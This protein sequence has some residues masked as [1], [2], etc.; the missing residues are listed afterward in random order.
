MTS[1]YEEKPWL[2]AYPP[3]VSAEIEIPNKSVVDL[4]NEATDK[5]KDRTALVFY[6]KKISF[7]ELREKADRFANALAH[8]GI[9]KGERVGLLALNS[10]EH[11]IAFFGILKAGAIVSSISPVYVSSEVKHQ[12]E[13]GGVESIVCQDMLFDNVEKTGL[14]FKNVILTNIAESLPATKKMFGKSILRGVYQTMAVPP[15]K[16]FKKEGF[17]QFQELLKK[18]APDPPKVEFDLREDVA[19][20]QYTGG[21][22]GPPKGVMSTHYGV[23]SGDALFHA[24]YPFLEDGKE[25]MLAYMPFY[26]AAGQSF[27]LMSGIFH[28]YTLI[29]LTTPDLDDILNS[30]VRHKVTFILG[31]PT[32]YELLKDY[33]KTDRVNWHRFKIMMSGADALL[34]ST[35]KEWEKRTGV[36]IHE[37]YGM[38]ETVFNT[39]GNP[40]GKSRLGSIGVP[41]TGTMA[42]ILDPDEDKFVP[43][44]EKGELVMCG[45]QITKGYWDNHEATKD[46]EAIIDGVRWWRSGD[47][48]EM[49]KDGYFSIYDRKRDLIKY[50]GLRVYAREVEEVLKTHPQIRETGVIGVRDPEVGENVK[51]MIVL[52]PDARG[53]L[54]E[55]DI[56]EYCKDKLTPYKIPKIVEFIGEIPKTDVGKVS[57]RELR[58]EDL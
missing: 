15:A 45:P 17:Y 44:G 50:K 14:E 34:E 9:K 28:G 8:L 5:W 10:P 16:I 23:A 56:I 46:C 12:L 52:E 41:I 22:T 48:A 25:V 7:G 36:T 42:A 3:E 6:G 43:Q 57:R 29:V 37:C 35:A 54:S 21:T 47:L 38:T 26:H 53:K 19:T 2:K 13:D 4:F 24:F 40:L 51:A 20:L 1:V 39:H 27:G 49:G 11:V 58:E 55:M 33:E 30:I 32:I 18:H 31:A